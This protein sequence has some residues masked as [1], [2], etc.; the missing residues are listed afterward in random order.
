MADEKLVV[1]ELAFRV[2]A[3]TVVI[4]VVDSRQVIPPHSAK[5]E[6]AMRGVAG[7]RDLALLAIAPSELRNVDAAVAPI[8]IKRIGDPPLRLRAIAVV[9]SRSAVR[10]V[11]SGVGQAAKLLALPFELR[12]FATEP[13]ARAWLGERGYLR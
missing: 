10:A 12:T 4:N 13:E 3:G 2:E 11:A 5:L 6:V 8:W 9:T 7:A 1:P